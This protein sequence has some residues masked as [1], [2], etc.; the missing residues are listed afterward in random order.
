MGTGGQREETN[1]EN[2]QDKSATTAFK[3]RRL[4]TDSESA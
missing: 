2:K 1:A 4:V 3:P